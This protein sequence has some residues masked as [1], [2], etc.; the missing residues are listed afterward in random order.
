MHARR[1]T[2]GR[3]R[4]T[5][6]GVHRPC[7]EGGHGAG[8]GAVD[9]ANAVIAACDK[10]SHFSFLYDLDLSIEDKIRKIAQD[11]YGAADIELLPAAVEKVALYTRQGFAK[12]P[13]CMAKTQYSLSADASKKGV[14]TGKVARSRNQNA[15]WAHSHKRPERVAPPPP[16]LSPRQVS[17]SPSVTFAPAWVPASCTRWWARYVAAV[18]FTLRTHPTADG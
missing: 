11:I 8:L 5:V 15:V 3:G 17:R 14:P 13:I 10:P 18:R 9:L 16:V 1:G 2:L 4:L 6:R 12:L 7:G